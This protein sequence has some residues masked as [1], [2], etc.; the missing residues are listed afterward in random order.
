MRGI[1]EE[2]Y[3]D[4]NFVNSRRNTGRILRDPLLD[5]EIVIA[6]YN[7]KFDWVKPIANHSHVYH[8]GRE[9]RPPP[10][11]LYAWDKLP[12]VGR[13][14]HTYLYHIINNYDTL[15]EITVFVQGEGLNLFCFSSFSQILHN[16]KKNASCKVVYHFHK[17]WG[18]ILHTGKWLG[19]LNSWIMRRSTFTFGE[20]F[21]ELF[22]F[23]HPNG[24]PMCFTGCFAATR[25]M[26]RK[27]PIDFYKKAIS[28]VSNNKNPEEGHYFERLWATVF[29]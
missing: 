8:K 19:E 4:A 10:L 11:Q 22:G 28:F 18:R 12:N 2:T 5:Y 1:P 29:H 21:L 3:F 25:N 24:I 16:I 7:E 15:P 20:F 27:H 13:E 6:H 9:M 17:E 26:I 14:F 23:P